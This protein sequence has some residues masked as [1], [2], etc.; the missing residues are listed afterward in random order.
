MCV[1]TGL[2]QACVVMLEITIA[3]FEKH[4]I[5]AYTSNVILLMV[6]RIRR[7]DLHGHLIHVSKVPYV[8]GLCFSVCFT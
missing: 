6:K 8:S 2:N 5:H 7:G 4:H 3:H 1:S